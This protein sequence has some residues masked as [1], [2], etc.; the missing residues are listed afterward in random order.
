[1]AIS[2]GIELPWH[3]E[4]FRRYEA[5]EAMQPAASVLALFE[6]E[7]LDH[8]NPRMSEMLSLLQVRTKLE[9]L[10]ERNNSEEI[11]FNTEGDIFRNKGR[12]LTS[13]LITE[14]KIN[15]GDKL[16]LLEFGR[17]LGLGLVTREDYYSFLIKNYKFPHPAFADNW[18]KWIAA[19]R[20][21]RPF[22]DLLKIMI[23]LF[24]IEEDPSL[25]SDEIARFIYPSSENCNEREKAKNIGEY[26]KAKSAPKRERSDEVDRKIADMLGF[27]CISGIC[28]YKGS[29]AHLNL[30]GVHPVEKT[31]FWHKRSTRE[32]GEANR[33]DEIKILI[34]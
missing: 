16:K 28:F 18:E 31:F 20:E 15:Q 1:M 25:S 26:R 9:W 27:L 17:Q 21:Y 19:K 2:T 7:A 33:L 11:N 6:G 34:S 12:L 32:G 30:V 5:Y 23:E 24:E 10:P 3:F 8:N 22:V 29:S 4:A 13:L 14:P